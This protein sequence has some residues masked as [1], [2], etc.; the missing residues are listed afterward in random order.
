MKTLENPSTR[1]YKYNCDRC[2][3]EI[4]FKE[5]NLHQIYSKYQTFKS[6]KICDLCDKCFRSFKRGVFKKQNNIKMEDT[7]E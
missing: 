4:S 6:K 3:K 5:R 1:Q 7:N 2:G